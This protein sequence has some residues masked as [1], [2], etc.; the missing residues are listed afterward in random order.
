MI[1]TIGISD[2]GLYLPGNAIGVEYLAH[3]RTREQPELADHL[4]RALSTTGQVSLRFPCLWEDTATMAAEAAR[5]VLLANPRLDLAGLRHLAVGTETTLD[6]AKPLSAYVQGML[7]QAGL[8]LP[9]SLSSFQVQHACAGGTLGLLGVAAML[10]QGGCAEEFGLVLCSDI[11]RYEPRSTA[12][13]TQGA[14]AAALLVETGPRLLELELDSVGLYSSD[15]DDFFRP[16]GCAVARVKGA[17]SLKCYGE[18]LEG[19]FVDHCRRLG[20][21]PRAVLEGTDMIVLHTPFHN[22]PELMMLRLL[23]HFLGLGAEEGKEFLRD[24]GLYASAAP[25]ARIGNT[26]T[27][28]LYLCLAALLEDRLRLEG[29]RVVGRSVLMASY[30]SG[31]T[32]VVVRGRVAAGASEVIRRWSIEGLLH[33]P[34]ETGWEEYLRWAEGP[35]HWNRGEGAES[36]NS[37]PGSHFLRRV[38]A[39]G[40]REYGYRPPLPTRR[41]TRTGQTRGSSRTG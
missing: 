20:R 34:D 35:E 15:V 23:G 8:P 1:E 6:H 39:D 21:D 2:I 22:L 40:Y 10:R 19:A 25:V 11:A 28:S 37:H 12:E 5:A 41:I 9:R 38:R 24:R 31:N 17:Y 3:M 16:L 13:V 33:C 18:S 30:G 36:P 27:A 32:M 14:G 26:Y 7:L 29:D 4:S